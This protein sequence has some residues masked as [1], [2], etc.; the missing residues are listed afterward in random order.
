MLRTH[1]FLALTATLALAGC[2]ASPESEL[3]D[4]DGE[5]TSTLTDDLQGKVLGTSGLGLTVRQKPTSQSAAIKVLPEGTK[6]TITCQITG[7]SISGNAV[8]NFLGAYGGYVSDAFLYTG[9][10][11]FIPG[12]PKCGSSS[13]P[14]P[15]S[16]GGSSSVG[17]AAVG[18]ARSY[19]GYQEW[20]GNCN[21]FS[22]QLGTGCVEWCSD[23]V[24]FVWGKAGART[25][26]LGPYS[27]TF[28]DYAVQHGTWKDAKAG[29]VPKPGDAVIWGAKDFSWGAHVG[30]VTEVS[31]STFRTIHG[32]FDVQGNGTGD[33]LVKET[34]FVDI[35]Y[36]AGTGYPMLGF[37]S[38]VQ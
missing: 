1:L 33:D 22:Q 9:Y 4:D 30:M 16:G 27:M 11:G 7:Q 15:P 37:A 18:I 19:M 31:G 26:G 24:R 3:G 34:G 12:V 6:A 21:Y 36:Q 35:Y 29:V 13:P 17:A 20:N 23:F 8:W 10:D 32:N 38:P 5:E 2:L 28:H 25:G 14:P